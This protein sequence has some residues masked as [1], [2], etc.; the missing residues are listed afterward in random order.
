VKSW[1][2]P[3]VLNIARCWLNECVT[4]KDNTVPQLLLLIEFAHDAADK[5]YG[6]IVAATNGKPALKPILRPYDAIGSTRYVDF[7]T[8]R[9][10][11]ATR[12]DKCHVSHVVADTDSWE[13]KLAQVLED[14]DEV[15]RYVKNHNLG[16]TIPYTINGEEKQYVP[17]FVAC[18]DGGR[19]ENDLLNLVL[20][21]T[22]EKKKDKAAKVATA[23]NLWIPAV[24]NHG[25][26]GRWA[27][28]E[29]DDPWNAAN[30]IRAQ[31]RVLSTEYPVQ[32]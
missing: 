12:D 2:F 25:G 18:I 3:Q 30:L 16:F 24:N 6:S 8:T 14:M 31:Y 32:S 28:I 11:Y 4:L 7:D 19:G 5:I 1:L 17:D 9:P 27:F 13:Q 29:I 22:G 26:L 21:V 15:R 23:R 10:V 20:E